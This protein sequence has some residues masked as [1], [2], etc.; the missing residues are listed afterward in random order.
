MKKENEKVIFSSV[1]QLS[2]AIRYF[3]FGLMGI[4]VLAFF[5]DSHFRVIGWWEFFKTCHLYVGTL[6][7]LVVMFPGKTLE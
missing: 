3:Y 6:C 5:L 4:C 1:R 2:L 7:L